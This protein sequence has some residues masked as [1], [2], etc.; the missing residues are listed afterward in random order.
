MLK[1]W[2][3]PVPGFW[4]LPALCSGLA[5]LFGIAVCWWQGAET[6]VLSVTALA[7]FLGVGAAVGL[8]RAEI[9]VSRR[10][11]LLVGFTLLMLLA[12]FVS[13]DL[14]GVHRWLQV[15]P[16][17]LNAAALFLPLCLV[18]M[19]QRECWWSWT[20]SIPVTVLLLMQPDASQATAFA[21]GSI[22]LLMHRSADRGA[23]IP[24][25][26]VLALVAACTWLRA[27]P[28][29]AALY[30]EG[31]LRLAGQIHPLFAAALGVCILLA[32]LAPILS[33]KSTATN[34]LPT[35]WALTIYLLF[36]AITP[37]LGNY[38]MPFVGQS[39]SPILGYWLGVGLLGNIY[40]KSLRLRFQPAVRPE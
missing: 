19:G 7:W 6:S 11:G 28:L 13:D 5:V 20:A 27:D 35:A 39:A 31:V 4:R 9:D 36:A 37:L 38:P 23:T 29:A 34:A 17:R 40:R 8:Q 16:L 33:I 18:A 14:D 24:G 30:V 15:G 2:D 12:T 22:F 26:L 1:H 32:C 25:A 21:A 3:L 10:A